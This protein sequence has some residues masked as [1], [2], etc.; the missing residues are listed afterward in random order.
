MSI[1]AKTAPETMTPVISQ[2]VQEL[3]P[4][5]PV[6]NVRTMQSIVGESIANRRISMFLLAAFA[7]LALVLAAFGLYSVLAYTS[8]LRVREIGI[9]MALGASASDVLRLVAIQTFRPTGLA[10]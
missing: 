5:Q 7:G 10:L 2:V 8:R 1:R 4:D 9:R 6:R 3:T